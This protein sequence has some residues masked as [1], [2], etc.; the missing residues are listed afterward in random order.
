MRSLHEVHDWPGRR[1]ASACDRGRACRVDRIGDELVRSGWCPASHAIMVD[2]A[3][4]F[5]P[6]PTDGLRRDR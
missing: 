6:Q 2:M 3:G 4:L 5:S 1:G